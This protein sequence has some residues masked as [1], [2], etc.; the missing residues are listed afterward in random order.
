MHTIRKKEKLKIVFH[1]FDVTVDVK[2]DKRL[3][4]TFV[5]V[6]SERSSGKTPTVSLS[7]LAMN[8][9]QELK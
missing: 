2:R 9:Y 4:M 3:K 5:S 1:K 6:E 8:I 7:F